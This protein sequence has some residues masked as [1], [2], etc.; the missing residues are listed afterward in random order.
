MIK[1]ITAVFMSAFYL[2]IS[3]GFSVSVHHCSG[4]NKVIVEVLEKNTCCCKMESSD[5]CSSEEKVVQWDD[6]QQL[7]SSFSFQYQIEAIFL[8]SNIAIIEEA[9]SDKTNESL[10]DDPPP[11]L[12][13]AF[14]LF[15]QMTFY[16]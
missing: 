9:E 14:I 11:N 16:G 8:E 10:I 1:K 6:D 12:Q 13:K 4:T 15:H 3:I 7:I 5:C 2:L